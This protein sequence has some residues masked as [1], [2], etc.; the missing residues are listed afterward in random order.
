MNVHWIPHLPAPHLPG[1]GCGLE[2]PMACLLLA[3]SLLATS[4]LHVAALMG[5]WA[6]ALLVP[7]WQ[8]PG[9]RHVLTT[10]VVGMWTGSRST[11]AAPAP[12]SVHHMCSIRGVSLVR[13]AVTA[14]LQAQG[15]SIS[16]ADEAAGSI[17]AELQYSKL[18]KPAGIALL[19]A[20]I[21]LQCSGSVWEQV[22]QPGGTNPC[23][24]P[25]TWLAPPPRKGCGCH[26]KLCLDVRV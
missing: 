15:A 4:A 1:G 17:S 2:P 13:R 7:G 26:S 9:S 11:F 21:V 20:D 5:G 8:Q 25:S 3:T 24:E 12:P 23:S 18:G 14:V 6:V 22:V 16:A 10:V 19:G